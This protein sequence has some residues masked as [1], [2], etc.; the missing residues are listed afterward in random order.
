MGKEFKKFWNFSPIDEENVDLLIYDN[1]AM[2]TSVDWWTGEEGTEVTPTAFRDELAA[3]TANNICVRINSGGGDVFAAESIA[4]AIKDEREKGKNITCK[5]DGICASAAVQIAMACDKISI[6]AS[7]YM[8]IHDPLT[9]LLGYYQTADLK[10]CIKTLDKIKAGIV[11]A[12]VA[13]TGID[14]AKIE[15]LMTAE[16]WMTG[17][18]AVEKG[19]ADEVLFADIETEGIENSNND[20]F[21]NGVKF[22]F[23]AFTNVPEDLKNKAFNVT[24]I[25][26]NTTNKEKG[27]SEM[28]FKNATELAAAFPAFVDELTQNARNE[29]AQAERDRLQALDELSGK[30]D[31]EML[32]A[33]KYETLD[34]AESV[35]YKAM[36]EGK[37]VN[38]TV[39]NAMADDA[40]GANSV[41]GTVNEGET[42]IDDADAEKKAEHAKMENIANRV[43]NRK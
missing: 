27:E 35:A 20:F 5:I 33:A 1:I 37:F 40:Q 38:T 16:T 3:I 6:P 24:H 43:F 11:N 4:N 22:N 29:A 12:Y 26:N 13:K 36:K 21:V 10:K 23:A 34:T 30:V 7:A 17:D 14:K 41:E 19:F 32:N 39:I 2:K 28:E 15:N 9:L 18:E 8:M 42:A 31:G 25:S